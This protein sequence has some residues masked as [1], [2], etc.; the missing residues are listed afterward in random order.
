[1][2]ILYLAH[3]VPY[4]PNKGD[5]IRS[6]HEIR[7]FSRRH[8]IHL[9]AF[10]DD[11]RDAVQA[12]ALHEYCRTVTL[13]PLHRWPQRI[14]AGFSMLAGKPWT[15][16]YFRNPRIP[17]VIADKLATHAF[18]LVFAYSSSMAPYAARIGHLP[19]V[20]DFVD[21]DAS[22]WRQYAMFKPAPARWLYGFESRRLAAFEYE[23]LRCFQGSI[24]VSQRETGHLPLQDLSSK[25]HYIQ[26]GIDLDYFTPPQAARS[27]AS[28]VFTGAM[29]YFPNIDAVCYFARE[30][31]P[32]IRRRRQDA[33]FVIVGSNP[34][35]AVRGLAALP[36]VTVTGAVEDVRPYLAA[37]RVAVVPV[38][39]SQ[40]IQNKI[41][42][43]LASG[44]PVVARSES[45]A[46]VA[47]AQDLPMAVADDA[48]AFA[49]HVLDF[50]E[51]P[52]TE[53]QIGLC[54]ERLAKHYGWDVNFSAFET[55]FDR[56]SDSFSRTA[57]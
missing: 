9:I 17:R 44:L 43:A 12:S 55:V 28:V 45:A 10:F 27:G 24:F 30:I 14:R 16:G 22:K 56:V 57:T 11:P 51:K 25:V 53:R 1:M 47:H 13:V 38:R 19:K 20:L 34:A 52:L 41:L 31:L 42:E 36:G 37:A 23:M 32:R 5:K 15:Q 2:R 33:S 3:R 4:P 35:P 39:I 54:R 50:L 6:F 7:S 8:E 18:D 26:N 46:G 29:D 48:D 21:S 40:G 49:H